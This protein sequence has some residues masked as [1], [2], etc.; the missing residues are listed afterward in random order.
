MRPGQ[1]RRS[2]KDAVRVMRPGRCGRGDVGLMRPIYAK[3][4]PKSVP[5]AIP[6]HPKSSPNRCRDLLRTP[7]GARDR[8]RVVSGASWERPWRAP[9]AP[10]ERQRAAGSPERAPGSAPERTTAAKID[11][12]SRL[13]VEKFGISRS[14]CSRSIVSAICRR[15]SFIFGFFVK[16]A[17][18]LKCR[19]CQQKQGLGS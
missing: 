18:A 16:C 7:H 10:R 4:D 17:K 1:S 11:P 6:R 2:G 15:F 13:G 5:G 12:E 8:P 19:A 9:G 3:I 14:A